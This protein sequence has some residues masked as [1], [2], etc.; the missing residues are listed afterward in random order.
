MPASALPGP[1]GC[2]CGGGTTDSVVETDQQWTSLAL[3]NSPFNGTVQAFSGVS[4]QVQ[5][6][7][8]VTPLG[9]SSQSTTTTGQIINAVN[10]EATGYFTLATWA[11]H[12]WTKD[13][14]VGT[15]S[16]SYAVETSWGSQQTF[17]DYAPQ[18]TQSDGNIATSFSYLG[19]QS[20]AFNML[21]NGQNPYN[22]V[23]VCSSTAQQLTATGSSSTGYGVFLHVSVTIG[24]V[25]IDAG[26]LDLTYTSGPQYDYAYTLKPWDSWGYQFLSGTNY[27]MAFDYFGTAP[28]APYYSGGGSPWI[29][30]WNGSQY[31][32]LNNILRTG[33]FK[34]G[35]S[36][37]DV[38][39]NYVMP[40]SGVLT[41][42]QY[43]FEVFERNL[44]T[45]YDSIALYAVY[46][47]S[48][49]SLVTT[50]GGQI[51]TYTS[52]SPPVSAVNAT[53][54]N[55]LPQLSVVNDGQYVVGTN[56][57]TAYLSFGTVKSSIAKLILNAT[58][59]CCLKTSIDTYI[60]ARNGTWIPSGIVHPRQLWSVEGLDIS[61]YLQYVKGPLTMKLV[62]TDTVD[63]LD[64]VG[65]D[66]SPQAQTV[67]SSLP[68]REALNTSGN[69]TSIV[70]S[71]NG[72]YLV[73]GPLQM[74]RVLFGASSQPPPGMITD[75]ILVSTGH[76]IV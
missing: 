70:S 24:I 62:F 61:S 31:V 41:N 30:V 52:P 18:G 45:N 28:C 6:S 10:G 64:F 23:S 2:G 12:R 21:F 36:W 11:I 7:V 17:W 26:F 44:A 68:M 75:L 67:I 65:L 20:I 40:S 59:P 14:C 47:P 1:N 15:T 43:L 35:T 37:H 46:H 4:Q 60:L 3:A 48:G 33:M 13:T 73:F 76:Y 9:G 49:T 29:G 22:T 5:F 42:G 53:G 63:K 57:Y 38:T 58:D 69:V 74:F 66:T 71:T 51:L 34:N 8:G 39:D 19:Y 55:I 16:G 32:F 50:T 27:L 54:T 56:G 72:N 25:S